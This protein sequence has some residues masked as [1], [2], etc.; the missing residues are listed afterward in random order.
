MAPP[1][2]RPAGL[3]VG[4]TDNPNVPADTKVYWRN[5]KIEKGEQAT[6]YT[7]APEDYTIVSKDDYYNHI[8]L[9][10]KAKNNQFSQLKNAVLALGGTI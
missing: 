4:A 6:P 3:V 7:K 5:F 1:H 10:N 2:V 8:K 9:V